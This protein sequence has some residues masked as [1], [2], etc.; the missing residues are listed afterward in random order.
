M[1]RRLAWVLVAALAVMASGLAVIANAGAPHALLVAQGLAGVLALAISIGLAVWRP[2]GGG[3]GGLLV[4]ALAVIG[5]ASPFLHPGLEGAHRWLAIGP[6]QLQ[7]SAITLPILVWIVA[8]RPSGWIGPG[9]LVVA[10]LV[11]AI[12]PDAQAATALAAAAVALAIVLRQNPLWIGAAAVAVV[13]VFAAARHPALAPVP[14][15]E[16]SLQ[17]AV[18]ANP[19]LGLLAGAALAATPLLVVAASAVRSPQA[20]ALG[21]LWAGFC[22]VSL[23]QAFPAPVI[24][25]GLSWILGL[26]VTLG[27]AAATHRR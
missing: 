27:L 3:R 2:D 10:A 16:Q 7:P 25:F 22:A 1:S 19:A 14:Y 11:C 20:F 18:E 4:G 15:V 5:L 26:G 17:L 21:T 13:G 9:A 12:Q 24:G 8:Q 23:T 6:M